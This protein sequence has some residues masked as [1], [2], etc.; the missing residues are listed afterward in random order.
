MGAVA[1]VVLFS[2]TGCR[3][4]SGPEREIDGPTVYQRHCARC[5]GADGRGVAEQQPIPNFADPSWSAGRNDER[6]LRVIQQGQP[7]RMPGFGSRFMEPTQRSLIAYIRG[8]S[9]QMNVKR[10]QTKPA[11]E[12]KP[13]F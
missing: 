8:F 6:L 3:T 13:P 2:L 12:S 9:Q 10:E 4:I 7:P 5:H 11:S 1:F